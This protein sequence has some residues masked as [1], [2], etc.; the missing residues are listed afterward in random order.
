[1]PTPPPWW[2]ETQVAPLAVFSSA[3][4]SGQSETASEPSCMASVSRLGLATDP[5]SKWSRP[6]T[7]GQAHPADAGRQTLKLNPRSRHV[8]P[9]VQVRI[10]GDQFL[11]LRIGLVDVLRIARQRRPAERSDTPAEQRP[12]V[13][14]HEAREI[15]G[16]GDAGVERDLPDIVAVFK[17][18]LSHG[19]EA[20]QAMAM[21]CH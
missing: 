20:Q 18:R 1:M 4:S 16:T 3:L 8:E 17:D 9:M 7:L 12:D 21:F 2:I 19:L 15:K 10:V 14:G 5:E 6:M 13:F 11:D